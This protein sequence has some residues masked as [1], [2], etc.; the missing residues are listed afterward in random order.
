MMTELTLAGHAFEPHGGTAGN[1]P[2]TQN[3]FATTL[4]VTGME[5]GTDDGIIDPCFLDLS[6]N[7]VPSATGL[8]AAAALVANGWTVTVEEA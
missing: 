4:I 2:I 5:N 6:G 3:E 7:A 1:E 8:A